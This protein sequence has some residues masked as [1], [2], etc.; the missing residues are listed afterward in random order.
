MSK[1]LARWL[2]RA[3]MKEKGSG[4]GLFAA[5][6]ILEM[7]KGSV[8]IESESDRGTSVILTLPATAVS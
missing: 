3:F 7:H 2:T 6:H 4:I 1:G 8:E 5:K